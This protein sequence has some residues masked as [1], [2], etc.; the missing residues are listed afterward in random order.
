M[1]RCEPGLFRHCA[2]YPPLTRLITVSFDKKSL[3]C[4]THPVRGPLQSAQ[5]PPKESFPSPPSAP[6]L[7]RASS[8]AP[9]PIPFL[10]STHHP[11]LVSTTDERTA[12]MPPDVSRLKNA[13]RGSLKG[14]VERAARL[15]SVESELDEF[16]GMHH[17]YVDEKDMELQG[18]RSGNRALKAWR[19]NGYRFASRPPPVHFPDSRNSLVCGLNGDD[20]RSDDLLNSPFQM[21]LD[22]A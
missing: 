14:V 7:A 16:G 11:T 4:K 21:L 22:R 2:P 6:V 8:S 10:A 20:S 12:K 1:T 13:Y 5:T 19:L 15:M 3:T 9:P 18:L 17:D